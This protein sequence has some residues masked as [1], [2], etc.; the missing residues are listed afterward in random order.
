MVALSPRHTDR[1]T[2]GE[3]LAR[4]EP[5]LAR[6][7]ERGPSR[8]LATLYTRQAD[9][10]YMQGRLHEELA[11]TEQG[12]RSRCWLATRNNAPRRSICAGVRSAVSGVCRSRRNPG[13]SDACD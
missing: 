9:L 1:G 13:G 10:L 4:L 12:E 11:A 2:P 3:G 6:L 8:A 7:A 5:M